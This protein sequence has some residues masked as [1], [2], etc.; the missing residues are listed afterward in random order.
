MAVRI[1][2]ITLEDLPGN[3]SLNGLYEIESKSLQ[4]YEP[5]DFNLLGNALWRT[6][7]KYG[8]CG[9]GKT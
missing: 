9:I 4:Q 8:K 2:E 6:G 5:L 7:M 1:G 3:E